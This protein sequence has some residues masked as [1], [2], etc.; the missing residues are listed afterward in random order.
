MELVGSIMEDDLP[1]EDDLRK[2]LEEDDMERFLAYQRL[3]EEI[4]FSD[5]IH[6]EVRHREIY[7]TIRLTDIGLPNGYYHV[8]QMELIVH[9]PN[10]C[11]SYNEWG[12]VLA[13]NIST[14]YSHT[15]ILP[16]CVP[17]SKDNP[18]RIRGDETAIPLSHLAFYLEPYFSCF[19]TFSPTVY[20]KRY[21]EDA[22]ITFGLRGRISKIPVNYRI[23]HPRDHTT[24]TTIHNNNPYRV[25]LYSCP[26]T[27]I[28]L[29]DYGSVGDDDELWSNTLCTDATPPFTEIVIDSGEGLT[30]PVHQFNQVTFH[31]LEMYHAS[32]TH[33]QWK[34]LVQNRSMRAYITIKGKQCEIY[35]LFLVFR[36][37]DKY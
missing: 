8:D 1:T 5:S 18:I 31:R 14:T 32:I 3:S 36:S 22:K 35:D 4:E 7:S 27:D 25:Y 34:K 24:I 12:E 33:T 2:E 26:L 19:A 29:V 10:G 16:F 11:L 13:L 15:R 6:F 21:F 30:I 23:C 20:G 37:Q 28:Y 9:H 17:Q